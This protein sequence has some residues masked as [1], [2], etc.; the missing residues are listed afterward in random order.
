MSAPSSAD[1]GAF[2][3]PIRYL[4]QRRMD[5]H[6]H[7]LDMHATRQLQCRS[8]MAVSGGPISS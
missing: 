7:H 3:S 8:Y 5:L 1:T 2:A 6:P 4:Q